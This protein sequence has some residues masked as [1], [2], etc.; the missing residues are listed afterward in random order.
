MSEGYVHMM[1]LER[2]FLGQA[3]AR[4][5]SLRAIAGMLGRSPSTLSRECRRN[6]LRSGYSPMIAQARSGARAATPAA[7]VQAPPR[8]PPVA[9]RVCRP[10]RR[11]VA[12]TDCRA[13]E[14]RL[15]SRYDPPGESRN[16]LSGNLHPAAREPPARTHCCPAPTTSATGPAP[17]PAR[18]AHENPQ[19]RADRSKARG[20]RRAEN[21]RPLGG[22]SSHGQEESQRRRHARGTQ[23]PLPPA[24]TVA[25]ANRTQGAPGVYP[26]TAYAPQGAAPDA[27]LRPGGGNGRTRNAHPRAPDPHLL[28][29]PA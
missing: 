14:A 1:P 15:L 6:R 4:D 10:S 5:E 8:K 25:G 3:L 26:K 18:P 2:D 29:R 21:P 23:E 28:R 7:T 12:G 16:D 19:S 11:L 27:H 17:R 9:Q 20:H 22:R 24:R 13:S